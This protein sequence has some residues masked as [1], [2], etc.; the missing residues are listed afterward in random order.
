MSGLFSSLKPSLNFTNN[1]DK[2]L[3]E[4]TFFLS[5]TPEKNGTSSPKERLFFL[6]KSLQRRDFYLIILV[7]FC[8]KIDYEKDSCLCGLQ[9][10]GFY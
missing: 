4:L 8:V 9:Q 3:I 1:L 2:S 6:S 10:L 5:K 7:Y